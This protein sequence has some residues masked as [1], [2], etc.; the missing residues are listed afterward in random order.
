[1]SH[2]VNC[3]HHSRRRASSL[4]CHFDVSYS[5]TVGT[6]GICHAHFIQNPIWH[7][8]CQ[9]VWEICNMKWLH[10]SAHHLTYPIQGCGQ[11]LWLTP[12][13]VLA[14]SSGSISET[15]LWLA[16]SF[17]MRALQCEVIRASLSVAE[18]TDGATEDF[19]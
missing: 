19:S 4:E 12:C 1:M 13:E 5:W 11:C 7:Q 2:N 10:F 17:P 8:C 6:R 15:V 18:G 3:P 9:A 14:S 16:Q